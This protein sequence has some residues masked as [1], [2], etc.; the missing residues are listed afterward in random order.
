M[1]FK[2]LDFEKAKSYAG[3]YCINFLL[4]IVFWAGMLRKSFNADTIFHMVV[5]DAD[6]MSRIESGRYIVGL[7]DYLLSVLGIRTTTNLSIFML[8]TFILFAFAMTAMQRMFMNWQPKGQWES[9]GYYLGLN[10]VFLNVLF[11]ELL[12]FREFCVY[13]GLGYLFAV[14]GVKYFVNK[15]YFPS[16][17]FLALAA[18]TYQYT[19]V[20]AAILLASYICIDHECDLS[21][22]AVKTE[23]IGIFLC[24]GLGFLDLLSV[25]LLEKIGLIKEFGKKSGIGDLNKKMKLALDSFVDL[26]QS[27]GGVLPNLWI[28]LMFMLAITVFIVIACYRKQSM[29]K[30]IYIGIVL[31]GCLLLLYVIPFMQMDFA[32]P[33]RMSFCFYLIQGMMVVF[34]YI[35][36]TE[37]LQKWI[38]LLC[39]GYLVIQLLFSNFIVTNHFIS[40]TLDEVYVNMMYQEVL[41]YEQSTGE[42]VTK[43]AIV[44]DTYAPDNYPEVTYTIYQIN[45]RS[46]GTVTN[47]LVWVMT[48]RH[49]ESIEMDQEIYD[50]YFKDK[51]WD[52]FDLSEQLVF[53]GDTVYWCIY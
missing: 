18:T 41:K 24:M 38:T 8:L 22:R 6:V 12:M 51:N 28:P 37:Q 4:L 43:M 1:N 45:E 31:V 3:R 14:L 53:D 26:L 34:A 20:F 9:V 44:E 42:T 15:R 48:G 32:F 27:G 36:S 49:F 35:I 17:I 29:K 30:L 33:P 39:M 11:S 16:V 10:L 25:K 47:S 52:Y 19:M 46:L 50:Q 40:N 5:D 21:V 2:K 7:G 23:V 13:F